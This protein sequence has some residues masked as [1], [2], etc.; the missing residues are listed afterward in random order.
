MTLAHAA[1]PRAG[2]TRTGPLSPLAITMP[3]VAGLIL[4]LVTQRCAHL[5]AATNEAL[6]T[7]TG[8]WA[9]A[10][11]LIGR[12]ARTA[13]GAAGA[14]TACLWCA[15]I[16]FYAC[17]GPAGGAGTPV[18]WLLL[19]ITVGPVLGIVGRL[20]HTDGVVGSLANAIIAGWL[21]GEAAH[22]TLSYAAASRW[23]AIAIDVTA[24]ACWLAV[25]RGPRRLTAAALLPMSLIAI[26]LLTAVE[27][28]AHSHL[29]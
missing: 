21:I 29:Y 9:V 28:A 4:G 10:A 1:Q 26:A 22:T 24:V 18:F 19:I 16:A 27:H 11:A 17:G 7:S 8:P 13:W 5:G 20:T 15:T 3:V 12:R 23:L 6:A 2:S 25:A 14:A